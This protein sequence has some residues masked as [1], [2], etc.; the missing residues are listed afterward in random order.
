M[1]CILTASSQMQSR[2]M[3][4]PLKCVSRQAELEVF[5]KQDTEGLFYL[6]LQQGICLLVP[7]RGAHLISLFLKS[8]RAFAA[9]PV[10]RVLAE[11]KFIFSIC[12]SKCLIC[13]CFIC[14]LIDPPSGPFSLLWRCCCSLFSYLILLQMLSWPWW[15]KQSKI[16]WTTSG[17]ES[18]QHQR[19]TSVLEGGHW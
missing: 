9:K 5:R 17:H 4:D 10:L 6:S 18:E 1:L 12:R 3:Q 8:V 19:R 7:P 15:I 14:V 16:I 2:V 11:L 13:I